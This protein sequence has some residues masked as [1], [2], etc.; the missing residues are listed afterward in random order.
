[1]K[2]LRKKFS[3][4]EMILVLKDLEARKRFKLSETEMEAWARRLIEFPAYKLEIAINAVADSGESWVDCGKI[5]TMIR[6]IDWSLHVTDEELR[7]DAL[8]AFNADQ[9]RL[10]F[11]PVVQDAVKQIMR[12]EE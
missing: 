7:A 1:M 5:V 9:K 11:P 12:G 10:G 3:P 8:R 4:A 6:Q 2:D